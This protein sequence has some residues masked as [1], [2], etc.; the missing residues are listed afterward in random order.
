MGSKPFVTPQLTFS[1]PDK[2]DTAAPSF[3]VTRPLRSHRKCNHIIRRVTYVRS[4]FPELD[5]VTVK[6]GLTRAASGMAVMGGCEIWLNPARTSY[7]TIAH[8]FVHLLQTSAFGVPQGEKSCDVF[9]LA[10]HWTLNDVPPS[11]VKIPAELIDLDGKI[12]AEGARLLCDVAQE[13]VLRRA[14]GLR[15]YIAFFEKRLRE[16]TAF[17]PAAI[18]P[19]IASEV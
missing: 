14:E 2:A 18:S 7:H 16:A 8:E 6:I 12:R 19:V 9:S 3:T 5:G 15:S 4:Y 10:R 1:F 13:A 11:Y 17:S